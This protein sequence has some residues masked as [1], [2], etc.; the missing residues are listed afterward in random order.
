M[1]LALLSV[2]QSLDRKCVGGHTIRNT[3]DIVLYINICLCIQGMHIH[4]S[5]NGTHTIGGI[6]DEV[7]FIFNF[8]YNFKLHKFITFC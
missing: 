8:I 6:K 5:Y 3:S 4:S 1:S 7:K 2:G